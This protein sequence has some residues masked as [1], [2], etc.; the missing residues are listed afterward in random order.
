MPRTTQ[1]FVNVLRD[2]FGVAPEKAPLLGQ[3]YLMMLLAWIT[4]SRLVTNITK[5]VCLPTP[6]EVAEF[7][8]SFQ[9][10]QAQKDADDVKRAEISQTTK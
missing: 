10:K 1:P 8:K 3:A 5:A 4:G 7:K 6:D 9:K 2:T